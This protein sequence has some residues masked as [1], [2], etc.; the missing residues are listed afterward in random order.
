MSE[1]ANKLDSS[2]TLMNLLLLFI[3]FTYATPCGYPEIVSAMGRNDS[4]TNL[5]DAHV[6][7]AVQTHCVYNGLFGPSAMCVGHQSRMLK[8]TNPTKLPVMIGVGLDTVTGEIKLPVLNHT[9]ARNKQ[10]GS[11]KISDQTNFNAK[12]IDVINSHKATFNDPAQFLK[13]MDPT[14][15]STIGGI[16]AGNPSSVNFLMDKMLD[17]QN[18]ATVV[19]HEHYAFRLA[20]SAVYVLDNSFHNVIESLPAK[21]DRTLYN[22]LIEYWGTGVVLDANAGGIIQQITSSK[23]CYADGIDI[24]NQAE[25]CMLKKL[26]PTQYKNVNFTAGFEEH[27]KSDAETIYGGDPTLLNPA[28]WSQRLE[29]F[30]TNPVIVRCNRIIPLDEFV[31]DPIKSANIRRAINEYILREKIRWD[32]RIADWT[33]N[34]P[35]KVMAVR[36]GSIHLALT[37][38][39][40]D[41]LRTATY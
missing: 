24:D 41:I 27:T 33:W 32:D 26:Y 20:Y 40:E 35:Q 13:Q 3:C 6:K 15:S 22:L 23:S 30:K 8:R 31:A 7:Q 2:I 38:W 12:D 4:R 17:G 10:I 14:K 5:F 19:T 21:Y 29:S 25:L 28:E 37:M 36:G 39:R 16:Y 18:S 1:Q 11:F 9:Y 34:R